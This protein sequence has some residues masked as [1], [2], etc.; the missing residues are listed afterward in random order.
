MTDLDKLDKLRDFTEGRV[1][2]LE[3]AWESFQSSREQK[4]YFWKHVLP[5]LQDNESNIARGMERLRMDLTQDIV[6][7]S[8]EVAETLLELCS[9]LE[10]EIFAQISSDP[11]MREIPNVIEV[12]ERTAFEPDA[13]RGVVPVSENVLLQRVHT[14]YQEW[15]SAEA[16][17]YEFRC[18]SRE[19]AKVETG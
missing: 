8:N 14:K 11:I 19:K 12:L 18:G 5:F 10:H 7:V 15:K 3:V 6:P 1:D 4:E 2:R 9:F 16:D 17:F 13:M